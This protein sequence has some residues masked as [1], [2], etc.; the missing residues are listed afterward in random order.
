MKT[1]NL[2]LAL[3]IAM[4]LGAPLS[5]AKDA[6]PKDLWERVEHHDADSN[7]VKI[8]YVALGK[9]PLIVMIHGFPDFWYTWRKQM[10][11]LSARYRVIAVDQRGYDLSDRPAGVE[12]YAMPLLV[13]DIGAVI[14]ADGGNSAV[15]VGHDWG[16]A[17]AW[18]LAMTHPEWIQ[19][20]VILNLPHPSG[21]QREIK[22]NPEQRKNSQY[23][24]NFQKPGAEKNLSPE[25]L[26]AWVKDDAARTHY[27]EAFN[28]SDFGAM[29]NYY[30][31]NY[32][33]P[34]QEPA[35]PAPSPLPKVTVPVLEFHGLGDQALLPGAL[36]GTW[37]LV[38]K[39]FTLVT[40]PGAGHFVQQDAPDLVTTT[41]SDWLSRRI[42]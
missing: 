41:M 13:N 19:A 11:V 26:A 35:A 36:S 16:G 20:L 5:I 28:R 30:R 9:G 42:H 1:M 40:I 10:E 21:I 33:H 14:K 8:H 3:F 37:D 2:V 31:A 4:F 29:L 6:P 17:V 24:F 27:I 25:K 12:Q 22:T 39:D 34:D 23:A 18:T 38:E 32:P 7:G 15:I